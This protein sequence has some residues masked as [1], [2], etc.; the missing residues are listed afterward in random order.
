MNNSDRKR[1]AVLGAGTMGAS[2]AGFF[3]KQGIPV[4]LYSRTRRTLDRALDLISRTEGAGEYV[5]TFTD[6][7]DA[8]AQA[9]WIIET[10]TEDPKIKKEILETADRLAPGHALL[11]SDTSALNIFE[12]LETRRADRVLITHFFNPADIMPLVELVPGPETAAGTLRE[13]KAFLERT[14]KQPVVL[15]KCIPGF[16]ANRLTLALAREA[17]YLAGEGFASM[18]DID[19]VITSTFGPRYIF[20]GI[21]DLY[22]QIGLDVGCAVAQDLLPQLC[23]STEVPS[24][25]REKVKAGELGVKT[26]KGLKD[27]TGGDVNRLREERTRKIAEVFRRMKDLSDTGKA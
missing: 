15:R 2:I 6:L 26:L 13:L 20:E 17:F 21:F 18:E 10:V 16:L 4:D 5:S 24:L 11:T 1:I 14:G 9:D 23:G 19:K 7:G 3:A 22:D 25:L 12:F 8:V 27:Y